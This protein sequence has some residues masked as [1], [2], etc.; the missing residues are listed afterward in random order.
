[1]TES[2]EPHLPRLSDAEAREGLRGDALKRWSAGVEAVRGPPAQAGIAGGVGRPSED[3]SPE[4]PRK[5]ATGVSGDMG[6]ED[7]LLREEDARE[8]SEETV[9]LG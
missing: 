5:R 7:A 9:D 4:L 3:A 8:E 2:R 1:V 6:P